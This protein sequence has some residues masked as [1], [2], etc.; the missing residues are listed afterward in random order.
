MSRGFD[1][2]VDEALRLPQ[3]EQLRLARTLLENSEISGDTGVEA[4]WESEIENRIKRIDAGLA[5]G[6]PFS[7]V[8]REVDKRLGR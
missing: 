4:A 7:E 3:A 1:E 6:R 2:L 5:N 8:L